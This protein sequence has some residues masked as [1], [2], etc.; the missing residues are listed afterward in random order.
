MPHSS[1]PAAVREK[2]WSLGAV[3]FHVC[4]SA[5]RGCGREEGWEEAKVMPGPGTALGSFLCTLGHWTPQGT[6][7]LRINPCFRSN[8][9]ETV[10]VAHHQEGVGC[11]ILTSQISEYF[12][13]PV[14]SS[15][16][17]PLNSVP[18]SGAKQQS[19]QVCVS[20]T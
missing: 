6:P 14:L 5:E 8:F 1:K 2:A 10:C 15:G 19:A 18:C 9:S 11:L 7:V 4:W 3:T 20:S 12:Q 16:L 17:C 13:G